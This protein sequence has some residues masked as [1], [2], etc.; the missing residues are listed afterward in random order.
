MV[1]CTGEKCAWKRRKRTHN[2]ATNL[3]DMTFTKP[4]IGKKKKKAVKPSTRNYDPRPK[5]A[6]NNENLVPQFRALL[7]NTVPSAV[8]LHIL[9]DHGLNEATEATDEITEQTSTNGVPL[10]GIHGNHSWN[11][12]LQSQQSDWFLYRNGRITA[13]KCKRV[14]SL[15]PTTSPSKTIKEV[16]VNNTPQ[17]TA[18]L[19]GLQNEDNIAEAF[20]N[21]MDTVEGKKGVTITKCGLFVSKTHGFLGASPDGIITDPEE[22]TPG[23]AEFKYIQV[24]PDETLTDV[25]LRQ[26]ICSKVQHNNAETIQLNKN[27]KY[28][29]Q[30]YQ[31]MFVTGYHWG[32]FIAQGTEGGLFYEKVTFTEAFWSPILN[33]V[34][35]F[36]DKFF[37]YELAYPRIQLGLERFHY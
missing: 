10:T 18:M 23:V 13:S 9:P 28:Y 33:K 14:A 36:F 34:E 17:S 3:E 15:K 4:E 35:N 1:T 16:L 25:L 2:E 6:V 30:L 19:Q 24:K 29:F 7:I 32:V 5:K 27:H 12:R 26:H 37:V 20:I 8:G 31:Q 11:T 22:T 21:K